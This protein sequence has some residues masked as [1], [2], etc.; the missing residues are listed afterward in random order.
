M[1]T[2]ITQTVARFNSPF[3][4]P[5][6]EAPQPAGEYRVDHDEEL[7]EAFT[8]LAWRRVGTFIHLPAIASKSS[9]RRMV[10]INPAVLDAAL[11]KD[12]QQS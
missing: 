9:T 12:Q 5:G 3:V 7:M 8:R 4:L 11:E 2:R 1:T 6:F 10:R